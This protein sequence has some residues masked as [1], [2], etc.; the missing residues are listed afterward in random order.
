M[1]PKSML[2]YI[3]IF[4]HIVSFS[5]LLHVK[6]IISAICCI[7]RKSCGRFECIFKIYF[8]QIQNKQPTENYRTLHL[9][10]KLD[11]WCVMAWNFVNDVEQGM[12]GR[13]SEQNVYLHF[14]PYTCSITMQRLS[15]SISEC[16]LEIMRWLW[17][18]VG[19]ISKMCYEL[20]HKDKN[21]K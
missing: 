9:Y 19:K 17:I 21:G 5:T 6:S 18:S 12:C 1:T 11:I 13:G 14:C 2:W 10:S 4:I 20:H 3:I 8:K 15:S 16:C 7:T